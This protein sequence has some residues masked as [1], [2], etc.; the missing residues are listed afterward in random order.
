M[1]ELLFPSGALVAADALVTPDRPP[2]E[3][4]IPTGRYR[5]L[6]AIK[7]LLTDRKPGYVGDQRVA[8]AKLIV[9]DEPAVQWLLATTANEDA[10]KLEKDEYYGYPV[11]AGIG[12]FMDAKAASILC[13]SQPLSDQLLSDLNKH[14]VHTWSWA[15][16]VVD[17]PSKLNVIAFS[18]G[19]G[20]GLYPSYFGLNKKGKVVCVVTDFMI[21]DDTDH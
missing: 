4:Q 3:T 12:S 10:R 13:Q 18:S 14:D 16:L 15:N 19:Y 2:F 6:V 8:Y 9:K 21:I 1:G 11:D 17:P 7:E 5:V 20:D